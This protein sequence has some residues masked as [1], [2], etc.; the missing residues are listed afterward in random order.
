VVEF[1]PNGAPTM[2]YLKGVNVPPRERKIE[3]RIEKNR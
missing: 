3:I 1:E 2:L